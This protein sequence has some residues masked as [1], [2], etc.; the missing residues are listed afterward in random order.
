[1]NKK[2]LEVAIKNAKNK[3]EA[4][5]IMSNNGIE[6]SDDQLNNI[7]GGITF[8]SETHK[9]WQGQRFRVANSKTNEIM[10]ITCVKQNLYDWLFF[11]Y[12]SFTYF[13][14][15]SDTNIEKEYDEDEITS[16]EDKKKWIIID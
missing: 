3:E 7:S 13:V 15:S 4:I 8:G 12:Q 16:L 6:L 11:Y 9:Y 5:S 2:E 1:M 14:K 10:T